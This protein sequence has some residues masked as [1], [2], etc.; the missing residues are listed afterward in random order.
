[1]G[2]TQKLGTIPLAIL[3]DA[4]NNVGIG[5]APS[6]SYK[7]EV[8]GTG[9][10]TDK[11]TSTFGSNGTM[12]EN[13]SSTTNYLNIIRTTSTGANLTMWIENS[14]GGNRAVGS[15]AYAGGLCTYT[16]TALQFGTDNNIRMTITSGGVV[17]INNTDACYIN[18]QTSGVSK[19]FI[20]SAGTSSDI[21]SGAAI[22]DTVIRAQQKMLFSTNGDTERMRIYSTGGL[23]ILNSTGDSFCIQFNS[24][25]KL[26]ADSAGQMGIVNAGITAYADL[27]VANMTKASGSFRISHPLESLSETHD[28]VHSFV[29]APKAD[30]IYRGKLTL[31]DGKGQA[32]IDEMA[33]MTEGTFELLCRDIQCFTTNESGWD[34]IK[35][36]VIGNIIYIE[37]QNP[38][39]TDEIS[40]MVIGERKDKE[41]KESIITDDEGNIIVEPLKQENSFKN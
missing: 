20:G 1:M 34:L 23:N 18:F 17:Q 12:I 24:G 22:G 32:N 30:L 8:T 21:I 26:R 5:A 19:T 4:S 33:T 9:R 13:T 31:V 38:N 10:F 15:L 28:L 2:L 35:G 7:L 6:G 16:S 25:F 39:S 40:W 11:I 27:R 3:T 14:T 36:K 41:I 37:S 29:E